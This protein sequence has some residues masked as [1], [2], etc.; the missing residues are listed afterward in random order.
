MCSYLGAE[1]V[2]HAREIRDKQTD[3]RELVEQDRLRGREA[4]KA[5][6]RVLQD[7]GKSIYTSVRKASVR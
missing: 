6:Q 2:Q 3:L 5:A 7:D 1:L 4:I